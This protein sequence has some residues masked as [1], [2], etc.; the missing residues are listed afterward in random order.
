M[1]NSEK[2]HWI[3][4]FADNGWAD[5][6]CPACGYTINTDIHVSVCKDHCPNCGIELEPEK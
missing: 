1:T 3:W 6:I 5:H 2:K 4:K